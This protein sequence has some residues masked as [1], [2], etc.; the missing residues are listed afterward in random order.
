MS[1]P[2]E[3][4]RPGGY[5]LPTGALQAQRR[6][7]HELEQADI[8]LLGDA[9]KPHEP[10]KPPSGIQW[11][12]YNVYINHSSQNTQISTE[13]PKTLKTPQNTQTLKEKK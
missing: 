4:N 6:A 1:S 3:P 2:T 13:I 12:P 10:T 11:P 8:H 9:A 5:A 7:K